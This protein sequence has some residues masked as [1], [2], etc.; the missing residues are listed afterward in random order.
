LLEIGS[1]KRAIG[2]NEKNAAVSQQ[3][4]FDHCI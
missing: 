4:K 1:F 3:F 2:T